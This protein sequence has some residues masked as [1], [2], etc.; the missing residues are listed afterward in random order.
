M[1]YRISINLE[2]RESADEAWATSDLIDSGVTSVGRDELAVATDDIEAAFRMVGHLASAL[3]EGASF[4]PAA[5]REATGPSENTAAMRLALK[6]LT[7]TPET[8]IWLQHN[9]PQA[10]AQAEAALS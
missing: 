5:F 9:D 3:E 6:V 8:R 10:L 1:Q 2:E 7:R 4:E